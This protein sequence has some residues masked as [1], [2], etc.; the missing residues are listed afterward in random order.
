[1]N[2]S[3]AF[4]TIATGICLM[5]ATQ[6]FAEKG[7]FDNTWA[8]PDNSYAKLYNLAPLCDLPETYS[9]TLHELHAYENGWIGFAT[10]YATEQNNSVG[11]KSII[12][13]INEAGEYDTDYASD[14]ALCFEPNGTS[15]ISIA[16]N[17][18]IFA[19]GSVYNQSTGLAGYQLRK[20]TADGT[21]DQSFGAEGTAESFWPKE[22]LAMSQGFSRPQRIVE[23][24]TGNIALYG[25]IQ[26]PEMHH[27]PVS[28][29][30][31]GNGGAPETHLHTPNIGDRQNDGWGQTVG[32]KTGDWLQSMNF[33]DWTTSETNS[34]QSIANHT[35]FIRRYTSSSSI[36]T[37]FGENGLINITAEDHSFEVNDISPLS[38]D[39]NLITGL[40]FPI[41]NPAA[42]SLRLMQVGNSGDINSSFNSSA[43]LNL[44][45]LVEPAENE[46][47]SASLSSASLVTQNMSEILTFINQTQVIREGSIEGNI[48]ARHL[49]RSLFALY[50]DGTPNTEVF[51]EGELDLGEDFSIKQVLEN[52]EGKLLLV[53]HCNTDE[54]SIICMKQMHW[55]NPEPHN[56]WDTTPTD[57][58]STSSGSMPT[59][60]IGLLLTALFIRLKSRKLFSQ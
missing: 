59:P 40:T 44:P 15:K 57:D 50:S 8:S 29:T 55:N 60:L 21:F 4:K 13:K 1:M 28:I 14:G 49:K 5:Q 54:K 39:S 35:S 26:Y 11:S 34:S 25:S 38:S 56:Q 7:E 2:I 41:Q 23:L 58:I 24:E 43:T 17:G 51:T 32:F 27:Q 31:N 20:I 48:I 10:V 6:C 46:F 9:S 36:D 47:S 12:F 42:R 33:I 30:F 45:E 3:R 37:S 19:A 52:T 16:S 18:A 22:E 53:G